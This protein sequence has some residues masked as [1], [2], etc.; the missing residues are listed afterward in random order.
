MRDNATWNRFVG[1]FQEV[2]IDWSL[3]EEDSIEEEVVVQFSNVDKIAKRLNKNYIKKKK[4]IINVW[5][6]RQFTHSFN[7]TE[8]KV[9]SE[10][11]PK[12][13]IANMFDIARRRW[14]GIF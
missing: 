5:N 9:G 14:I 12:I 3:K 1:N 10:C 7:Q 2:N 11:I 13:Y 4:Q 6:K 8:D